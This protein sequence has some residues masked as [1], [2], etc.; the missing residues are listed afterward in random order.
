LIV[1]K[2]FWFEQ[3]NCSTKNKLYT[4]ASRYIYYVCV[5]VIIVIIN[6]IPSCTVELLS[7]PSPCIPKGPILRLQIHVFGP[8]L[9][10][11]HVGDHAVQHPGS[12]RP[13]LRRL[14]V[15]WGI[16]AA[17]CFQVLHKSSPVHRR[18]VPS[19]YLT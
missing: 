3:K 14:Q 16:T 18:S 5:R 11:L 12:N 17:D 15:V 13:R 8:G 1:N 6:H 2:N 9:A 10:R 4:R 19:G 7:L